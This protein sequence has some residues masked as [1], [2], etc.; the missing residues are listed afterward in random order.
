MD[1]SKISYEQVRATAD[2]LKNYA[3]QMETLLNEAKTL[4]AKVGDAGTWAGTAAASVK[5][6]FDKLSVRFPEFSAA[7]NDENIYL[8]KVVQ[9]FETADASVQ[10]AVNQ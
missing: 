7:V 6:S 5:D 2:Q 9:N 10:G 4:L 1:H 3:S 8:N